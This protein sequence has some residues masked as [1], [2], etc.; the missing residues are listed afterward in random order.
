MPP[1]E[2]HARFAAQIVPRSSRNEI[3][4]IE[5]NVV[6]IRLTAPAVAGAANK[7]LL[8]LLSGV[9]SVPKQDIEITAGLGSRKKVIEISGLSTEE[10]LARLRAAPARL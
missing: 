10:V 3:K 4:L 9:L 1:N 8:K 2:S 5:K 6:R 7:A